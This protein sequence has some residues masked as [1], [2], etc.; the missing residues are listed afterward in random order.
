MELPTPIGKYELLE[1]L[2]GGMS[3]VFRARDTVIDRPVV[4][5]ILTENACGDPEAKARFL[6]EARLAGNVQHENIVAVYDYGEHAGRPFMVMEYLRGED[7]RAAI[8]GGRTGSLL[9]RLRIARDVANALEYT[10]TRGII[11]R[12]IKPEN[13]HMDAGGKVKLMDFGI[14][15]TAELSLTRTGMAMGTPFYMAPEQV[16]G[17]PLT[18]LVDVYAWGLLVFELLTGVRSI[19]AET[20]EAVF[21]QILNVPLDTAALDQAGVPPAI[22]NL[23]ARCAAKESTARP[24]GFGPVIGELNATLTADSPGRTQLSP[25]TPVPPGIPAQGASPFSATQAA[26]A[27]MAAASGPA[28]APTSA[29][30]GLLIG[31][32][33]AGV[34][35]IGFAVGAV[36]LL[37]P[38]PA[39]AVQGMIYVPAGTSLAGADK[40][41]VKLGAFYIDE[42]EVTN[43]Q[44]ADFCRAT[45]CPPPSAAAEL[46]VVNVTVAEAR[47]FARWKGK[48][49]PTAAEWERAA[50]GDRGARFPWG[51]DSDPFRANVADNTSLGAEHRLGPVKSFA[52]A[53]GVFDMVGNAFEMV[54]GP[55]KPSD[56]AIAR[57]APLLTPPASGDEPWIALRGGSF[58]TPLAP[59]LVWDQA[60]IPERFRSIDT[61]FRC[62]KDPQ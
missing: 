53:F 20:M 24:Q 12:D 17:Q 5:K 10:H 40:H 32:I 9:N 57:F 56:A 38:K 13:I 30:R 28:V 55:V 3:Q 1:Y 18:P 44:F 58:N 11:H 35:L 27:G 51:D 48:R 22:R 62:A 45:G 7:L 23:V 60:P 43:A 50:R 54:D 31:I 8:R 47:A 15:K 26:G 21:Y 19:N 6:Q 33:V 42:T 52:A 16:R 41:P 46:P 25:H 59:D 37:R 36:L 2:G 39:P 34:A 29:R 49:L 4:V 61:G 14:A